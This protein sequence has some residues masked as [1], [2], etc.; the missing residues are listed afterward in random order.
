MQDSHW[1]IEK[2]AQAVALSAR[3]MIV[4]TAEV[5]IQTRNSFKIVLAGG[6]TP[7]QVYRL[8]ATADCDWHKWQL[9]LGD[10]RCLP[11]EDHE[12]NSHMI[13]QT[14]LNKV[15]VPDN[16]VHFIAAELGATQAALEYEQLIHLALPFDLVML[17]MG[18]DG[19]TASLFPKHQHNSNELVHAV[20]NAPKPPAERV[21]LSATAL[22]Q[23]NTLLRII[24][25][26]N[27]ATSIALWQQ[28]ETFPITTISSRERDIILLDQLAMGTAYE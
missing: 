27:K 3:D 10:E 1:Q 15:D 22:S 9:Y 6:T 20:F 24:T 11:R 19:H 23:N 2:D 5:A 8:L 21:S 26:T 14:L 25:G 28:G 7:K 16:N 12:R 4:K 17:G 13:Q 18:E